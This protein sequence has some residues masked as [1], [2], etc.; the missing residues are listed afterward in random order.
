MSIFSK[1]K[2]WLTGKNKSST[3]KTTTK[4]TVRTTQPTSQYRAA[5]SSRRTIIEQKKEQTEKEK[6]IRDAFKTKEFTTNTATS[7][8]ELRASLAR[9]KAKK[10]TQTVKKQ[11][12]ADPKQQI[13]KARQKTSEG[14]KKAETYHREQ[15]KQGASKTKIDVPEYKGL[16]DLS[17]QGAYY[18]KVYASGI[19]GLASGTTFGLSELAAKQAAKKNNDY[20]NWENFYQQNKSKAAETVGELAGSLYGFSATGDA[21]KALTDKA[22]N[23]AAPNLAKKVSSNAVERLAGNKLVQRA[24]QREAL[25][26]VGA[27]ATKE[28][29]AAF[30]RRRATRI[31]EAIGEDMAINLTTGGISDVTHALIDSDD[32]QEFAKN[33]GLA[34]G[35]NLILG[36][37]TTVL[38]AA[39]RRSSVADGA[40]ETLARN[41][42]QEIMNDLLANA[43]RNADNALRPG[44][45]VN[46][47]SMAIDPREAA[48]ADLRRSFLA[49]AD[50]ADNALNRAMLTDADNIRIRDLA[51]ADDNIRVNLDAPQG[52]ARDV[53]RQ[54]TLN[55]LIANA[56]GANPEPA[57]RTRLSDLVMIQNAD[58]ATRN[59]RISEIDNEL[60]EIQKEII[61]RRN[62]G[63]DDEVESLVQR[64]DDLMSERRSLENTA[65]EVKAEAKAEPKVIQKAEKKSGKPK[66]KA[67]KAKA[68]AE[69]KPDDVTLDELMKRTKDSPL[70]QDERIKAAAEIDRIE[71]ENGTRNADGT[72]KTKSKVNKRTVKENRVPRAENVEDFAVVGDDAS[73]MGISPD[74]KMKPQLKS[75]K[76]KPE[77]KT[78]ERVGK[79]K[80]RQLVEDISDEQSIPSNRDK[81]TTP[82]KS[83]VAKTEAQYNK[84]QASGD[85]DVLSRAA[86]TLKRDSLSPEQTKSIDRLVRDG[87]LN[88][89]RVTNKGMLTDAAK[90]FH[91][92]PVNESKKLIS[93]A[94]DIDNMPASK[95]VDTQYKAWWVVNEIGPMLKEHPEL[96]EVHDAAAE[97]TM[98]LSSQSGQILQ[99][100]GVMSKTSPLSRR[101]ALVDTLAEM[102]DK[103]VG[104]RK[105]GI[106]T[107]DGVRVKLSGSKETRLNQ[108]KG[109]M[110]DD[111]NV[112]AALDRIA[113]AGSEDEISKATADLLESVNG[114][115]TRTALDYL[116]QWRIAGMLGNPKTMIRNKWG[117]TQF[118]SIRQVS[119][120][121]GAGIEDAMAKNSKSEFV[122]DALENRTR[123]GIDLNIRRQSR[124]KGEKL[125]DGAAK[126]AY[127]AWLSIEKDLT[128][129]SKYEARTPSGRGNVATKA[130]D[131]WSDLVSN[132][133][134]KDDAKALE[135]NFREAY[136]KGAKKLKENGKDLADEEVRELLKSRSVLEAQIATFREYNSAAAVLSKYSNALYDADASL[137]KKAVGFVVESAVPFRKTP[138]NILK[139]S[140]NYSPLGLAKGFSNIRKAAASEDAEL[141]HAAIDQFSS[142][143]TGTGIA[144]AG[145]IFGRT[146]DA[147][148]TNAGSKDYD[149]KFQKLQGVQNYSVTFTDPVTNKAH[150]YTLDWLVPASTTFFAGVELANQLS[151]I[152]DFD[153][154]EAGENIGQIASRVVEPVFET[155]MLSSIYNIV[156]TLRNNSDSD[157]KISALSVT[158]REIGQ[159]YINSLVPTLV[160]QVARTAYGSDKQLAGATD[161]EYFINSLKNKMGLVNTDIITDRLGADTDAY[162]EVKNE[163]KDAKDYAVSALKNLVL[164]MNIQEVDLTSLDK[165]KIDE[166]RRRVKAG[167]DPESLRYLFP[168]KQY[169]KSF[170]L[171]DET[172][173]MNNVELSEYNQ[174]KTTGGSE[175]MRVVLEGIMFNRYDK[176]SNGKKT[177]LRNG[178]TDAQKRKLINE[179]EGK[180]LREVEQWLYKQPQFRSASEEER[181]KV[182]N[183]LWSLSSQGK[184]QGAKRVGE[185]AVIKAQGGDVNEY[186]FK[187]EVSDK[188]QANLQSAIDKGLITYDEAVDFARYAGKTYYYENDEGGT[189]QTY[190]NKKQMLE[191]L[192]SKGYS[193]E[194]AE[195]L[196]NAFKNAN[197]KDYSGAGSSGGKGY[198]RRRRG[199][200]RSKAKTP[201]LRSTAAYTTKTFKPTV[202]TSATTASKSGNGAKALAESL[203]NIRDVEAKVTPPKNR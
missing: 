170:K 164:P 111:A 106:T 183:H 148:T 173:S 34:A 85:K 101:R 118:G 157:D 68:E 42:Q 73:K 12:A 91:S 63:T 29:I 155:S 187:N 65:S 168:Q 99:L 59:A 100:N 11:A 5:A 189:S 49:N 16:D 44:E 33:M 43:E 4:S 172:I 186:N 46:I 17:N 130:L 45:A 76:P 149:E 127:D 61:I 202:K 167:E 134:E 87:N 203:Q 142:G 143:L 19:R 60:D 184:A 193:Y 86:V 82:T 139:E 41:P 117:N 75:D 8:A 171:G 114:M 196:Y 14:K 160:G 201:K 84:G 26:T 121:I 67:K 94:K 92:D 188:K 176:D 50:E 20:A 113:N 144:V 123:G 107:I 22:V 89:N 141:L 21:A 169:R 199:G 185:Q 64:F 197:A 162:G 146:T 103:S 181:R 15:A 81:V 161:T 154:I 23:K 132:R 52:A 7:K 32:P 31:V 110:E 104:V 133:L 109:I 200:R 163:K 80:G 178:Y 2:D 102:L 135:R 79:S 24:A 1:I 30:A 9:N 159:N 191:Y 194:K 198:Y 147:F 175:G 116:Q 27:T 90:E 145:Y 18:N 47:R 150:S 69:A 136:M 88:Y 156:E 98:R 36:G 138:M 165:A 78:D 137:G 48:A 53:N 152:K 96:Q 54:R 35:T 177:I 140:A 192:Q 83:E 97:L 190:Y 182:L 77:V 25:R 38:P 129:G 58:E 153:L 131:W 120:A 56:E 66:S 71:V 112:K 62:T 124:I 195:A 119:N 115:K 13:L 180:S 93:Y 74:S 55:D 37:L 105:K 151:N 108:I 166:Y 128:S 125:T 95:A 40:V 70:S 57:G 10:E 28:E 158:A 126:D 6:Q 122:R 72:L 174:A 51:Q 39:L 179:F 3:K